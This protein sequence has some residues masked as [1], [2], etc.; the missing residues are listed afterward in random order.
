MRTAFVKSMVAIARQDESVYL[1]TGDLG[2]GVLEE[3]RDAFPKRFYNVG[4]AEANMAGVAAGLA[5]SGK[6]PYI[7]SIATFAALRCLEQIRNDICYQNLDVTI[8]GVG[9]GL[10]YSLY[11]ASHQSIDDVGIMR[12][13]PNLVVACAGDPAETGLL[14]NHSHQH[15][16]PYYLRLG[17][18]G[19]PVLHQSPPA[20]RVGQGAVL[21]EG[22]DM[23]VMATG[24]MLESAHRAAA[25]LKSDGIDVRLITMPYIKPID[26]ELIRKAA[27]ETGVIVSIEEHSIIGGLGTAIAEVLAEEGLQPVLFKRIGLPDVFPPEVGGRA[28]LRHIY[29]LSVPEIVDMLKQVWAAS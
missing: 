13:L 2:F 19:E 1:L 15:P 24:N 6:K 8:V 20:F 5:L 14:M 11:G 28:Y 21:L 26:R 18:K 3:F 12:S 22:A 25:Q 27:K 7:Y 10:S 17:T 9:A 4:V 23:T 16:G 29:K